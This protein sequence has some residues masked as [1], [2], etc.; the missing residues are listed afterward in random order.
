MVIDF[1]STVRDLLQ[2]YPRQRQ[3][4]ISNCPAVVQLDVAPV[5]AIAEVNVNGTDTTNYTADLTAGTVTFA[6]APA[7]LVTITYTTVWFPDSYIAQFAVMRPLD[8]DL[9]Q[10]DTLTWRFAVPTAPVY[11]ALTDSSG[12]AVTAT[13]SGGVFTV[14]KAVDG[15]HAKGTQCDLFGTAATLWMLMSSD[16]EGIRRKF[17]T[18]VQYGDYA[19]I[20]S[21]LRQQAKEYL[22]F[23]GNP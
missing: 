7:Q 20:S 18:N 8:T 10:T 12:A 1:L 5:A 22:T 6:A 13:Y 16:I 4:Q 17:G 11:V 3:K 19:T 21:A 14:A 15:L 23:G 9:L 2:D